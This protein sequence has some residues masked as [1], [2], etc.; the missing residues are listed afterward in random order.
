MANSAPMDVTYRCVVGHEIPFERIEEL[1]QIASLDEGA[2]VRLCREHG[3]P[4][5]VTVSR[6]GLLPDKAA[7]S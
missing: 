5:A 4:I 2:S 1:T 6:G 7:G 3:A